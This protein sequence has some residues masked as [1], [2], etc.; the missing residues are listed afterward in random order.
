MDRDSF[1]Y[2]SNKS[3]TGNVYV[4]VTLQNGERFILVSIESFDGQPTHCLG[5]MYTLSTHL[6]PPYPTTHNLHSILCVVFVLCNLYRHHAH[7]WVREDK[8]AF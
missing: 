6:N 3:T 2:L 8:V 1:L 5:V 4:F 7:L